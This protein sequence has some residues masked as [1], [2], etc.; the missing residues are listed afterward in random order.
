MKGREPIEEKD[1][2]IGRMPI[3]LGSNKC[4]LSGKTEAEIYK[5]GEC[6][7]DPKGY[8]IYLLIRLFYY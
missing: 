8:K 7:Y 1:I 2:L 3:M 4:N 5:Y 6:P